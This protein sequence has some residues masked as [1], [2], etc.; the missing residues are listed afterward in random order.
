MH[1][2]IHVHDESE[3][4]VLS[5]WQL[6]ICCPRRTMIPELVQVGPV[7]DD[8]RISLCWNVAIMFVLCDAEVVNPWRPR[9]AGGLVVMS[10]MVATLSRVIVP[11]A[12]LVSGSV[13]MG[14][15]V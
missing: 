14:M 13:E 5:V 9:P 7:R 6:W 8:W 15:G 1:S 3:S 12:R 11:Q 4:I 2:S 10:N